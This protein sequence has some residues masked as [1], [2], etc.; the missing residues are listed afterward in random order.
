[1][2][3]TRKEIM[4]LTATWEN[5]SDPSVDAPNS[6]KWEDGRTGTL[7]DL[8]AH[9]R[10]TYSLTHPEDATT[11]MD[12]YSE[13]IA[14]A[15]FCEFGGVWGLNGDGVQPVALNSQTRTPQIRRS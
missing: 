9:N 11:Q 13:I 6:I 5:G 1:M 7:E 10:D 8:R 3:P 15:K 14:E 12:I 2:R 4:R